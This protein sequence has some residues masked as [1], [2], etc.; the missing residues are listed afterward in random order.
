M[1]RMIHDLPTVGDALL[2]GHIGGSQ[3]AEFT[4]LWSNPRVRDVL[5]ALVDELIERA[6][7]L[8]PDDFRLVCQRVRMFADPDGAHADHETSRANRHISL[9]P[10]GAGFRLHA[11]GDALSGAVIEEVLAR[12]VQAEFDADWAAGKAE[13]GDRMCPA[14]LRRTNRQRRFDAFI[15]MCRAAAEAGVSGDL[16]ALVNIHCD[17]QTAEDVI[18]DHFADETTDSRPADA[19]QPADP[20][21]LLNR[22]CETNTGAPVD[23]TQ[24][25]IAM[26]TGR[27]RRVVHG[28]DG[29]VIDL[30]R[31]TRLFRGGSR[32]A[33]LLAGAACNITGC[34]IINARVEIDHTLAWASTIGGATNQDNADVLCRH[35]NR[36]KHELGLTLQRNPNM[37]GGWIT[38]RCD[39]TRIGIRTSPATSPP[40]PPD[41]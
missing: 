20:T 32:E 39:G 24:L 35:H 18:R 4:A 38:Y 1:A 29:R 40:P 6:A 25:L 26:L 7:L 3:I 14:L 11:E 34:S 23:P 22:R 28:G 10:D 16:V 37:P 15:Q 9:T 41:G 8:P 36:R 19:P 30:G 12:Y 27:V 21:D 31:R 5:P 33:A 17:A 2:H 13:H